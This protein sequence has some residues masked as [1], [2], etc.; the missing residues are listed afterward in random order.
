M[1]QNLRCTL[2]GCEIEN[3]NAKL[4]TPVY[5]EGKKRRKGHDG[6]WI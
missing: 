4:P 2:V 1:S 6:R 5:I 3:K